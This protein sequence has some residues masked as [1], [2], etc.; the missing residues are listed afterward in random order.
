MIFE[1]EKEEQEAEPQLL[2]YRIIETED[3]SY[4]GCKRIGV[5]LVVPDESSKTDVNFTLKRV[6]DNYINQ[7]DDIT[8]WAWGY[9]EE[10]DVGAS[11][12]TKG[13]YETGSCS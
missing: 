4:A 10:A 12:F 2:S 11:G 3:F 13:M 6:A 5:R 1:L 7:W 9:S 8:I